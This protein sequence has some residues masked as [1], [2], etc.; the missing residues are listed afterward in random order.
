M[1][2][3]FTKLALAVLMLLGV[4]GAMAQTK[5]SISLN[6]QG[7]ELDSK[8]TDKT[9]YDAKSDITV[10]F[11]KNEST[12][13]PTFRLTKRTGSTTNVIAI[14]VGNTISLSSNTNIITSV[15]FYFSAG[16]Y[17]AKLKNYEFTP[18]PESFNNYTWVGR[19]NSLTLKNIDNTNGIEVYKVDVTYEPASLVLSTGQNGFTKVSG[20][21][22]E[23]SKFVIENANVAAMDFSE[24]DPTNIKSLT[25]SNPNTIIQVA[26]EVTGGIGV[27][28]VSAWKDLGLNIVVKQGDKSYYAAYPIN[29]TDVDGCPVYTQRP[30]GGKV[31]YSYKRIIRPNSWATSVLPVAVNNLPFDAYIVDVDNSTEEKI[32]FTKVSEVSAQTPF[33]IHNPSSEE[34]VW[35]VEGTNTIAL[36]VKPQ[37]KVG[38]TLFNGNYTMKKGE[39]EYALSVGNAPENGTMKLKKF[40][41]NATIGAFRAYFTL[42]NP[43]NAA[44]INFTLDNGETTDIAGLNEA[45]GIVK[46]ANV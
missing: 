10:S 20:T 5:A 34:V 45:L 26:G 44:A 38:G 37:V 25:L 11:D 23:E 24:L 3:T 14:G 42:S 35:T 41:S 33:L 16:T 36:N 8:V 7:W 17:A 46:P 22:N 39:G 30:I 1:K 2:R 40:G 15:K 6:N 4:E 31:G 12:E 28:Y 13:E 21:Y 27:P 9:V 32:L 29:F 43:N 18:V 19:T